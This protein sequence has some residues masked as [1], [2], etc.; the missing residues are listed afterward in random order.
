MSQQLIDSVVASD[1]ES[2]PVRR[3]EPNRPYAH[4]V[5]LLHGVVSHSGWLETLGQGLAEQGVAVLA[6]DRRGAGLSTSASGD[7][8]STEQLLDDV[9]AVRRH[10][11]SDTV[12]THLGGF[13]WG[14]TYAL[15][16]LS[17]DAAGVASFLMIA[18]SIFP[19]DDIGGADLVVGDSGEA[20]CE[21]HV[22]IDRFTRGPAYEDFIIPDPLRTREV[23]PRFNQCLVDMNRMLGPRWAKL[24]LPTLMVLAEQDRLSHN[25]KHLRAWRHVKG[26]PKS[27]I[28]VPGEHGVQFDALPETIAAVSAWTTEVAQAMGSTAA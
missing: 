4:Q 25:E 18:P 14:A 17:R 9:D 6:V 1:G 13:C 28:I 3:Y 27:H 12:T 19:A 24:R 22:P 20:S 16:V 2:L 23:S 7:A 21:P 5:I 15:N 8:P 11:A 10:Y 26:T